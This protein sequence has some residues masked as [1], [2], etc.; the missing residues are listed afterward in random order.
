V[1][2]ELADDPTHALLQWFGMGLAHCAASD[3]V[4]SVSDNTE[5]K[6]LG[7]KVA[8]AG[9]GACAA[10]MLYNAEEGH[11][12]KDISYAV[13]AGQAAMSALCLWRGFC[14]EEETKVE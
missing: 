4:L 6:K 5:N 12:K 10:M 13:A 14:D 1:L 2:L 3:L 11:Q 7:L 9:W 8:G